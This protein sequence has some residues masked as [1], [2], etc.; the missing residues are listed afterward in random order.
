MAE[1]VKN[2]C[3]GLYDYAIGI[4][5]HYKL[6]PIF[7]A[8]DQMMAKKNPNQKK[9]LPQAESL[10]TMTDLPRVCYPIAGYDSEHAFNL[11]SS[12]KNHL[13]MIKKPFFFISALD[14]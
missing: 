2:S 11:A 4:N 9:M 8:Y 5:I 1:F 6:L 3:F 7:E 13:H 12:V 10:Y 14:D